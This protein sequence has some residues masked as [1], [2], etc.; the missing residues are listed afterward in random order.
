M[1]AL[2]GSWI[3]NIEKFAP[4][5]SVAV[6][7]EASRTA[8]PSETTPAVLADAGIENVNAEVDELITNGSLAPRLGV[9]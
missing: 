5:N 6:L 4:A 2:T 3:A 1:H 9:Q 7:V 8:T